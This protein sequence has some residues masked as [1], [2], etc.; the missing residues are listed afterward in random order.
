MAD[1]KRDGRTPKGDGIPSDSAPGAP[2]GAAL[3]EGV[4]G[5]PDHAGDAPGTGA[6]SG[7]EP[8]GASP[9]RDV[10]PDAPASEPGGR[11]APP[12]EGRAEP[13]GVDSPA[14]EGPRDHAAQDALDR[15]AAGETQ[16]GGPGVHD[17]EGA[18]F[19]NPG[20]GAVVAPA[21][22]DE[23]RDPA[24]GHADEGKGAGDEMRG[25]GSGPVPPGTGRPLPDPDRDERV[26]APEEPRAAH[27]ARSRVAPEVSREEADFGRDAAGLVDPAARRES[28]IPGDGPTAREAEPA[29]VGSQGHAMHA[30]GV[31]AG[32]NGWVLWVLGIA[33]IVAGA[34]ALAMP[35]VASFAANTVIAAMLIASGAVGLFTSFRR[36]DGGAIAIGFALSALAVVTGILMLVAP[37]AGIV[38]LS[39][40]IVAFFLA[41]GAIRIWYGIKAREMRGRGWL[42]A[43]GALSIV[44]AALL[45]FAFPASALW[46]PGM[47]LGIDLILY[48]TL[49]IS[50]AVFGRPKIDAEAKA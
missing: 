18:A 38:A 30:L 19:P 2:R 48:G 47:L 31:E 42:I 14:E 11:A 41:S 13:R 5:G 4:A 50:L 10:R 22:D 49:M 33:A 45:W 1:E 43:S 44:L 8:T 27:G 37:F 24:T 29:A 25:G 26:A 46:L 15:A 3:S 36:R 20:G 6:R 28:P 9:G 34:I 35:L 17:P 32:R 23:R 16:E 39:T 7:G 21:D 40:L 12:S